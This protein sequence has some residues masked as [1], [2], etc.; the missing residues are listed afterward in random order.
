[1]IPL[2]A[3]TGSIALSSARDGVTYIITG[4]GNYSHQG[5]V[6]DQLPNLPV[7]VYQLSTQLEDWKL[8]AETLTLHPDENLQEAVKIPYATLT[9][10]SVPP[11]ATIRDGHTVLGQTP[12]TLKDQR[13]GSLHLSVDLPPYTLQRLDVD[14]PASGS[15]SK[16]VTMAKD[17][18]FVAASGIAMV[19]IPNGEFWAQKYLMRQSFFEAI[20]RYN[21]SYFRRPDRPVE[22]ISW[23]H[24]MAFCD[25]LTDFERQAGK[26]PAGYHYTLP[27]ESQWSAFSA[28]ADI[29]QAAT[30]RTNSRSS[31]Q[32]V[33]YSEPN[34]YGLY[35]T[36]GNVWEWCLDN[37]D[38]KGDH[39]LRGGD[40]LSSA[41]DFPDGGNAQRGCLG[42][43]GP[44]YRIPCGAGAAVRSGE[45]GT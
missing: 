32:D 43:C 28:D 41:A 40:W 36:I 17:K 4:P 30:S 44:L 11:G 38:D 39:S 31:T 34:K 19:W 3:R 9:V 15:V 23:D 37:Y 1:M 14:L 24:A 22:S 21:P 18:D 27:T 7:G 5:T 25:K 12:L 33:G 13:P 2:A 20:A 8:P 42:L 6:P 26:L 16:T 29:N 10:E 45:R 35:D